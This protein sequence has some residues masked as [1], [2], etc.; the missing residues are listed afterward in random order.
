MG[1]VVGEL[2]GGEVEADQDVGGGGVRGIGEV[3]RDRFGAGLGGGL[4]AVEFQGNAVVGDAD[5]DVA[6]ALGDKIGQD[7]G[8]AGVG[9]E[10]RLIVLRV[11]CIRNT[12]IVSSQK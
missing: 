6:L 1:G 2:V 8:R 9:G 3:Q 4:V 12:G 11:N 10:I 5:D 7:Q